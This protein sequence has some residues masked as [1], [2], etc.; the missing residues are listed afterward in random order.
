MEHLV[1]NQKVKDIGVADFDLNQLSQL[2]EWSKVEKILPYLYVRVTPY[3]SYIAHN[4][5]LFTSFGFCRILDHS[6]NQKYHFCYCN[7]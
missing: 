1:D 2:Y 3:V 7:C 6:E 5:K 4:F